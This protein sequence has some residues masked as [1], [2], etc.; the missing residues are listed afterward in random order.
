MRPEEHVGNAN[1]I[2]E[3]F[4]GWPTFHDA[5]VVSMHLQRGPGSPSLECVIHVSEATQEIDAHGFYV[6]KNHT[7][8]TLAFRNIRL[9]ELSGFNHQNVIYEL[10]IDFAPKGTGRFSVY[11]PS[12]NGCEAQFNC[13]EIDVAKVEL[14]APEHQ[15][16]HGIDV[17]LKPGRPIA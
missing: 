4:G 17:T 5:E 1:A 13:D 11:L 2:T 12:S 9:H 8:V 6:Q 15:T 3:I 16:G 10:E 14:L 7:L